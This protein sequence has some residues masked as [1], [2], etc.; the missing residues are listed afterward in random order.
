MSKRQ[1]SRP[2]ADR[3]DHPGVQVCV[4]CLRRWPTANRLMGWLCPWCQGQTTF[5][6]KRED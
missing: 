4:D 6:P 2:V 5:E 3:T 1:P